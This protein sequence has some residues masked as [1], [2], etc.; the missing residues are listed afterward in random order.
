MKKYG[1]ILT[2]LIFSAVFFPFIIQPLLQ[3]IEANPG[4]DVLIEF[5]TTNDGQTTENINIDVGGAYIDSKN[6]AW[7]VDDSYSRSF[8][9][10]IQYPSTLSVLPGEKSVQQF[11]VKVPSSAA[12]S[13]FVGFNFSSA[14]AITTGQIA[15]KMNFIAVVH[16]IVTGQ[17]NR[18]KVEISQATPTMV[19][20][21]GE[22]KGIK[23]DLNIYNPSDW[24]TNT[25][26]R[27]DIV[28]ND[29]KKML[30]T[31]D[32][33]ENEG[34]YITPQKSRD[35][36]FQIEKLLPPGEYQIKMVFD[37][38]YQNYFKGKMNYEIPF[39][40]PAEVENDRKSL[41][42]STDLKE[43]YIKNEKRST[44]RG[45]QVNPQYTTINILNNDYVNANVSAAIIDNFSA[46]GF[47]GEYTRKIDPS[48]VTL[49]GRNEINARAYTERGNSLT[50]SSDYRRSDLTKYSG[51]YFGYLDI[52]AKG[53]LNSKILEKTM[54]IPIIV[55]FGENTWNLE[56]L[57]AKVMKSGENG[58]IYI[59][60]KNTG[61]SYIDYEINAI[62]LIS[63]NSERVGEDIKVSEMS[64]I[65][66][67]CKINIEKDI[68]LEENVDQIILTLKYLRQIDSNGNKIY[69]SKNITIKF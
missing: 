29:L 18:E 63:A 37:Y 22:L 55:D 62:K 53:E 65:Y 5:V 27:I 24:L 21:N 42:I 58:K 38:G 20:E 43:I 1:L 4:S 31:I 25:Y 49:K 44:A 26:G 60:L 57:D 7:V 12:G 36:S 47:D 6:P 30:A 3:T 50:V 28:S 59:T 54:R 46:D 8:E 10:W 14:N 17:G 68:P 66:P 52:D 64:T 13:Y 48:F 39:I 51:Q 34:N 33:P 69:D 45:I 41:Y 35:I 32:I 19:K 61:N 67:D 9:D 16:L 2:F 40:I 23:L 15:Y 56:T 11:T